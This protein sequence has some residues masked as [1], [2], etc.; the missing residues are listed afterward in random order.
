MKTD[1]SDLPG[2]TARIAP[3]APATPSRPNRPRLRRFAVAA[4]FALVLALAAFAGRHAIAGIVLTRGLSLLTRDELTIGEFHIGST[5]AVFTRVRVATASG[6]PLFSAGRV[7]LRY[8]PSELWSRTRRFGLLALDVDQPIVSLVRHADGSYNI[9]AAGPGAAGSGASSAG[10]APWRLAV[11]VRDGQIR[12]LD[13]APATPDLAEQ[14][15]VALRIDA[16]IDSARRSHATGAA[17]LLAR[18]TQTL[19]LEADPIA[20]LATVDYP[21]GLA[22]ARL[23][24]A[25]LPARG[26]IG[27]LQHSTAVRVDDGELRRV[28]ITAYGLGITPGGPLGLRV[29]GG[30]EL[31]RGRLRVASLALPVRDLHGPIT[32]VDDGVWSTRLDGTLAGLPLVARGGAFDRFHPTIRLALAADGDLRDLRR[33]FTFSRTQPLAGRVHVETL[34]E[35]PVSSLVVR[36]VLRVSRGHYAKAPLSD[37]AGRVDYHAGAVVLDG[38]RGRY[39]S[40]AIGV[41]ARF[42]LGGPALDSEIVASAQA[43]GR[44]LPFAQNIAPDANVDAVALISGGTAGY[45][46]RGALGVRGAATTGDGAF[47]VDE[48]GVG[49]FGPFAFARRDGSS[50]IGAL[51]LERP[52]SR[53]AA[54]LSARRYRLAVPVVAAS[55]AGLSVPAFPPLAGVVDGE[56]VGGGTPGAFA[57]VGD[58]RGS[59]LRVGR[60]RLGAGQAVLGGT[61]SD[62]RLEAVAFDGP[63]GAFSGSAAAAHGTF[64]LRGAYAGS[65]ER[66]EP[67]TGQ[68]EAHGAVRGDVL[69]SLDGSNVVVQSPRALLRGGRIRGVR[70][71]SATGTIAVRNNAFQIIAG[72]GSIMGRHAVAA[73]SRGSIA[74]SAPDIPSAA[75]RGT[76]LPLDAGNVSAYGLADLRGGTVRFAGTVAVESGRAHGFNVA[77]DAQ[78]DVAGPRLSISSATGA[79]GSTYGSIGGSIAGLGESSLA[80]DVSARVP[81]GDLDLL[82]RD[83]HLPVRHL[84]GTFGAD[85]HVHG[86]GVRPRVDGS[87]D[88][89]EGVYNGL[90][91]GSAAAR[92]IIDPLGFAA[93]DGHLTVGSTTATIDASV[94]GGGFRFASRS[95]ATNLSDF[96]DFF[97]F[98]DTLAGHGSYALAIRAEDRRLMTR[99]TLAMQGLRWRSLAFGSANAAW[100]MHGAAIVGQA[101][102]TSPAGALAAAGTILPAAGPDPMSDVRAARY[103]AQANFTR[104]D[105]GTWLPAAGLSVPIGGMLDARLHVTGRAPE[106]ALVFDANLDH[107]TI[108]PVALRSAHLRGRSRGS[109]ITVFESDADLGSARLE[110]N[111]LLGFGAADPLAFDL[112]VT[113]GDIGAAVRDLIPAARGIAVSGTLDADVRVGGT[114]AVP[115]IESGFDLAQARYRG[116]A[117]PRVIG[118]L[119]FSRGAI[120]LRDADLDLPH[121]QVF[122][123]GSLPLTLRPFGLGPARAPVSFDV[124]ARG[125]E[126]AQFAPLLPAGTS[127]GG[128]IDGRFGVEGSV[129]E[130]RTFGALAISDGSYVSPLE[131]APIDHVDARLAFAGTS[132]ALETFHANVGGGTLD[133]SGRITLPFR[134]DLRSVYR[135]QVV[136]KAAKLDFPAFGR[137]TIDGTVALTS[138][139]GQP[140]ISGDVALRDAVVPVSAVYANG[141]VAGG[142]AAN[143]VQLDPAFAIHAAAGDNVRVRSSIVDIGV[144]GAV[145]LSGTLQRPLLAGG[146]TATDGTISSYNHVFRIVNAA[147]TFNPADGVIPTVEARAFSRVTNPDPDQSRNI[148][149]SANIIVTVSGTADSNNLQVTYSSDPAYSQ[150]QIIGL[151]LDVPALLGAVNFNL[152]GGPG[153]PL[154][155]GV[156]GETNALLPPGVT[157]EQVSAISFN[158][159]VFSLLNGQL[160]QRALTPIERIFEK[161]LGL[162]DIEFTVDYG[163]GLGY[164]VRR[165]IGKHDFYAFLSQTVTYPERSNIGF[166]LQPKPYQT[167]NFSYYQQNGVT[168]L[169]TNQTPGQEIFSS[170]GRLTS[171]QP[172]G[173]RSGVSLNYNRRF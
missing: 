29:G 37:V 114:R 21:R 60:A 63:L 151:L 46:V 125:V 34:L 130:P 68:Q 8:T 57:L 83:L 117:V 36:S 11:R 105:L 66:L 118:S 166:E 98:D 79:L 48:R 156:P 85:L 167:I 129:A 65:L 39:G 92:V 72:A 31:I 127:L 102:L 110:A 152:N 4:V 23:S 10:G 158:E 20:L 173:D 55:L 134:G 112:R 161:N 47:A 27:Y 16:Q 104:V 145:D 142:A 132:V 90:A 141:S 126:L 159:E 153:A 74:L 131:R 86:S 128:T 124:T 120:E 116:F 123:A 148:A 170:T 43:P 44:S 13:R 100:G 89:P 52:T 19:R 71:D 96:N 42:L 139:R 26:L 12:F 61:L 171:V 28:V 155:R 5:G 150:E 54:W 81:F 144:T 135:A 108:G 115:T 157:P 163:G 67:L 73:E 172:L 24:A 80:Y 82:R 49:E 149:G 56:M 9:H 33:A 165:Q 38:V 1:R 87:I 58:L 111:G 133:G 91:F 168:S 143:P 18:R 109:R 103:D 119:A 41:G 32:L 99:G 22:L 107:G 45:R 70:L 136:A 30:G 3:S 97:D 35:A 162:S 138:G 77:G 137:G 40:A 169:I 147:V 64:A 160:T 14:R 50:L 88:V 69:A 62:L 164:S 15:I 93:H 121:G 94:G 51:R 75:L 17:Q 6:D 95:A 106:L 2:V 78:I 84:A 154:L 146:F 113:S 101:H 7:R 53:S 25:R 122:V 140:T 76:G 59:D